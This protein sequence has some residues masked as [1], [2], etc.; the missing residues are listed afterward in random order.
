M[1]GLKENQKIVPLKRTTA[2]DVKAIFHALPDAV[3]AFD[4]GG[5]VVF[6]NHAAQAFFGFGDKGFLGK[7]I[8]DLLG[9]ATPAQD[10]LKDLVQNVTLHDITVCGKRVSS[11]SV[12][13][14]PEQ[15]LC[16]LVLRHDAVPVRNEWVARIKR[17]LQPAQHLARVLAHEIKNPLAGIR[18]AAQLLAKS[19]LTPDDRELAELIDTE[20]QR[21]S[22]LI[23]KVNIFDDAPHAQYRAVNI[24]EV[25]EHVA[26]L[27]ESGFGVK[28]ATQYDPSLP[29]IHG[30]ADSLVQAMLNIVKNAAE[31]LPREGG[32]VS[33]RTFYDTAAAFHPDSHVK[34][35]ICIDVED[36]G[37]GIDAETLERLFEPY[38]TTKPQGEGLGLSIVS[39]IID[40]HGGAIGVSSV[41]GRT[42]FKISLP[43]GDR[44]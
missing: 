21:I 22:R 20:T 32:R 17:T 37:C 14:V 28:I 35:P 5:E 2:P 8:R 27:S 26:R 36:N 39:K 9:D 10:V 19:S 6:S 38:R 18:G 25:L 1:R 4:A 11:L 41:A 12:A 44:P 7:T 30:H 33:I 16:L 34:L 3:L 43:R 24:H 13:P 15:G 42:V 23:D 40:D 29:D 31:A